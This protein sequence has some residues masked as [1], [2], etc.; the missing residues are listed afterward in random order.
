MPV[1]CVWIAP[2]IFLSRETVSMAHEKAVF[3]SPALRLGCKYYFA[4]RRTRKNAILQLDRESLR[5]ET[6][7]RET[8][9]SIGLILIIL[10]V[11]LLFGGFSGRFRGYGYGY[12]HGGVGVLGVILIILVILL[13][14]GRI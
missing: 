7:Q 11:I 8:K 3:N 12:G 1:G 14:T 13:V 4:Q 6:V 10:L 5:T 9:M 2:K